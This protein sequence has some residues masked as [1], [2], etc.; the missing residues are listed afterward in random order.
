M[1]ALG[2]SVRGRWCS[3]ED[4]REGVC[5]EAALCRA[6]KVVATVPRCPGRVRCGYGTAMGMWPLTWTFHAEEGALFAL[7]FRVLSRR[8]CCCE[9]WVWAFKPASSQPPQPLSASTQRELSFVLHLSSSPP[10][11]SSQQP[12]PRSATTPCCCCDVARLLLIMALPIMALPVMSSLSP[13]LLS[14]SPDD[15]HALFPFAKQVSLVALHKDA[16]AAATPFVI[17]PPTPQVVAAAVA[18]AEITVVIYV[19]ERT[20]NTQ[21]DET[22]SLPQVKHCGVLLP[23]YEL[24]VSAP[25]FNAPL[26]LSACWVIVLSEEL[27]QST[28]QRATPCCVICS[29]TR[30]SSSRSSRC[31]SSAA[32]RSWQHAT[33]SALLDDA[34]AV[35]MRV[36]SLGGRGNED[37]GVVSHSHTPPAHCAS[38][39]THRQ[40]VV[41]ADCAQPGGEDNCRRLVE[42]IMTRSLSHRDTFSFHQ[43]E[44]GVGVKRKAA[45]AAA[46]VTLAAAARVQAA[47][48]AEA[49]AAAQVGGAALQGVD[50]AA[51]ARQQRHAVWL[52]EIDRTPAKAGG[53]A[54]AVAAAAAAGAS[55][56]QRRRLCVAGVYARKQART[57]AAVHC[58]GPPHRR[59]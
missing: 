11:A 33:S 56:Q 5:G 39:P 46:E 32:S 37:T 18:A 14:L 57:G 47:A 10:S 45:A 40:C 42:R 29:T 52:V 44:A 27:V 38:S 59:A 3:A 31:A 20:S 23:R 35:P 1:L 28:G 48:R 16:G 43:Q 21:A 2:Q 12:R 24:L 25:L 13:S 8:L 41:C 17:A 55:R 22:I 15:L 6:W 49:I 7:G 58:T 34:L 9:R 51:W 26:N 50:A 4:G 54:V 53:C 30:R 36:L 19:Y